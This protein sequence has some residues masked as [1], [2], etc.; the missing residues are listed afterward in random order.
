MSRGFRL[1]FRRAGT[2]SLELDNEWWGRGKPE[3]YFRVSRMKTEAS[4]RL[5]ARSRI[6]ET[7]YVPHTAG[8]EVGSSSVRHA[9]PAADLRLQAF[10]VATLRRQRG[11]L[12]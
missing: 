6:D 2:S 12:S 1:A 4:R 11:R 8:C 10:A 3:V 7:V 9:A 5:G